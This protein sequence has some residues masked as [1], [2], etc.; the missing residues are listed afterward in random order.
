MPRRKRGDLI[1]IILIR[2]SIIAYFPEKYKI[3][4]P[5]ITI[6]SITTRKPSGRKN[7]SKSP[8]PKA[9]IASP[10]SFAAHLKF[11]ILLLRISLLLKVYAER[12]EK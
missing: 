4:I 9:S 5:I 12:D 6:A 11:F 1:V 7:E 2:F 3:P 8:S 10:V